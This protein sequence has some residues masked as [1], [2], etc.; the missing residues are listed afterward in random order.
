[1][2]IYFLVAEVKHK[3]IDGE[4][5]SEG[6]LDSEVG[7]AG[8][9]TEAVLDSD[10]LHDTAKQHYYSKHKHIGIVFVSHGGFLADLTHP[11][12]GVMTFRNYQWRTYE[13]ATE[14]MIKKR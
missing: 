4:G 3:V 5:E 10:F 1:M 7:Q 12:K 8:R 2:R 6:E 11:P 9:N 13:F 14:E